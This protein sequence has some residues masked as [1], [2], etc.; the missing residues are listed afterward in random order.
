M[1]CTR[2]ADYPLRARVWRVCLFLQVYVYAVSVGLVDENILSVSIAQ[3]DDV[4]HHGPNGGRT[5]T[6]NQHSKRNKESANQTHEHTHTHTPTNRVEG[7]T[8]S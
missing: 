4:T 5:K 3:A 2:L 8:S 7:T 6:K 1:C